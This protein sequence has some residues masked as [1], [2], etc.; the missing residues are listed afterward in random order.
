MWESIPFMSLSA[1]L[2]RCCKKS[3]KSDKKIQTTDLDD[4]DTSWQGTR[5]VAGLRPI[6]A[7]DE[8][9]KTVFFQRIF[10]VEFSIGKGNGFL[11]IEFLEV[12]AKDFAFD[13]HFFFQAD[14][15]CTGCNACGQ[16][17]DIEWLR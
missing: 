2:A 4:G 13:H 10:V 8:L 9:L 1:V 14:N 15:P 17:V 16:D 12:I 7:L 11:R 6:V 3:E 5:K